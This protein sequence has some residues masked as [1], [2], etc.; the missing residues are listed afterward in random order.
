[1]ESVG[2]WYNIVEREFLIDR[3]KKTKARP[4]EHQKRGLARLINTNVSIL[5]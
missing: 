5:F 4:F 1:M 2:F 3:Y